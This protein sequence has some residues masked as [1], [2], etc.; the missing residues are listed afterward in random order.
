[1]AA[2]TTKK[3]KA[4]VPETAPPQAQ[5][6]AM[7]EPLFADISVEN[8]F[9]HVRLSNRKLNK[10]ALTPTNVRKAGADLCD[11]DVAEWQFD[12][13]V[14]VKRGHTL[15]IPELVSEGV[16]ARINEHN[17]AWRAMSGKMLEF[18]NDPKFR[19]LLTA[20]EAAELDA[21]RTTHYA[22]EE[23]IAAY[24]ERIKR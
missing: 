19:A 21:F 14:S 7:P 16:N 11:N 4:T 24:K 8:R 2:A 9:L 13:S 17:A 12:P 5:Q 20:D 3:K 6:A 15:D 22:R 23:A 18:C 10:Y 1:M